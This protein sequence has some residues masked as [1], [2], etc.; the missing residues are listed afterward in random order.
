MTKGL[1]RQEA[2]ERLQKYG[3]NEIQEEE[4]TSIWDILKRQL[5]NILIL[6]LVAAAMISL[7][8]GEMVEFYFILFIIGLIVV[9]GAAQEWKAEEAMQQLKEM[10]QPTAS[11]IRDGK[12]FDI[13]K[14][15]VV[16]GDILKLHTG[17]KIAADAEVREGKN[18]EVDESAMTGE[19][20]SVRKSGG[21]PLFS[22][23]TV[24]YGRGEA[25][26]T[27][28]GE[29]T[30]LGKIA[31]EL[32]EKERETPLQKRIDVLG[33]KLGVIAVSATAFL[34]ALGLLTG[35]PLTQVLLVA[36]A[37]TVASI[38]ESLPLTLTITLSMGVRDLA[39]KNAIVRKM[40][41][42]EGL[43]STT[44]ICTDKTGTL[45]KNEMT[46]EKV[47]TFNKE[48]DVTGVGYRPEGEIMDQ[49]GE[50]INPE[51]H[52][53]LVHL[54]NGGMLCNDAELIHCDGD[55][56]DVRGSPT[57]GALI[58]LG[59]KLTSTYEE[60]IRDVY[61]RIDEI[62]FGSDRKRM[63][64]VHRTPNDGKLVFMKGAPEIV[65]EHCSTVL[66]TGE[67]RKITEED[68]ELIRK[69]TEAYALFVIF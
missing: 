1:S 18:L 23:T 3:P 60:D 32:G 67:E 11:V 19:S 65:L 9:M 8:T 4:G 66:L 24:V 29:E 48:Y 38:P 13:P 30:G 64:T 59:E 58:T 20:E 42:V 26:V 5:K 52:P 53:V 16:S 40:L 56:C 57:E 10:S 62:P 21:D 35:S 22:G 37:L 49:E 14:S 28:T 15:E 25:R 6:I 33:K 12:V 63:S 51:E 68:R 54:L 43:G 27:E 41:A 31:S 7:F 45:T 61:P 34:L 69:Q 47:F 50:E 17:D 39:R 2:E 36:L 44:V 46:V 55:T